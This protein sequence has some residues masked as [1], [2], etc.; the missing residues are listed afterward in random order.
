MLL[1]LSLLS[2]LDIRTA[3]THLGLEEAF[4]FNESNEK[5]ILLSLEQAAFCESIGEKGKLPQPSILLANVQSLENKID[6][7]RLRISYQRDIK[8][9]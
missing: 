2:L 3:I 8:K 7:L 5:D 4:S 9:L 1:L 6:D